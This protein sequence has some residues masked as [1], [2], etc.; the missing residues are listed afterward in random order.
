MRNQ[1]WDWE[2]AQH[3]SQFQR[4]IWEEVQYKLQTIYLSYLLSSIDC[5]AELR[6]RGDKWEVRRKRIIMLL[7]KNWTNYSQLDKRTVLEAQYDSFLVTSASCWG[8]GTIPQGQ[9]WYD[10]CHP[11]LCLQIIFSYGTLNWKYHQI[12]TLTG[13][14]GC[15]IQLIKIWCGHW[16]WL[17]SVLC[18]WGTM[19]DL[20]CSLCLT[21]E[22]WLRRECLGL[23]G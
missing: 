20:L 18:N 10:H 17:P 13:D 6:E 9:A 21:P 3:S 1:V 19:S 14:W 7:A 4:F 16:D 11:W 22:L 8:R 5:C 15:F 12:F 2:R 23:G